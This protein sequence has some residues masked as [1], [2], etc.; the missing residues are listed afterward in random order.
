VEC[1]PE[2]KGGHG[3]MHGIRSILSGIILCCYFHL[4]GRS[5]GNLILHGFTVELSSQMDS[6]SSVNGVIL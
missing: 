2:F 1:S 6:H 3:R 4:S 5:Y